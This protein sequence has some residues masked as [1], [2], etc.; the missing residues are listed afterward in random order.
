MSEYHGGGGAFHCGLKSDFINNSAENGRV[1]LL[2]VFWNKQIRRCD[3]R[4]HFGGIWEFFT[5]VVLVHK[6]NASNIF[7]SN[8]LDMSARGVLHGEVGDS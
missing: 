8:F 5:C 7:F 1:F 4:G 6:C 3:H 2:F